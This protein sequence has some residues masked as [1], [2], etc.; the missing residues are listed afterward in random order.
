MDW[1]N[2]CCGITE[3]DLLFEERCRNVIDTMGITIKRSDIMKTLNTI[4][5][6][7][8]YKTALKR[9]KARLLKCS[10]D[11]QTFMDRILNNV[12][13]PTFSACDF[14]VPGS[15]LYLYDE[16]LYLLNMKMLE[17]LS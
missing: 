8:K 5:G 3:Y 1:F 9:L 10:G 6:N 14:R 15:V 17:L 16:Y 7:E 12:S 13:Y 2:V 11:P 4:V